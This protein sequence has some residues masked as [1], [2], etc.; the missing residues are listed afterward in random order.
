MPNEIGLKDEQR[1]K[2]NSFCLCTRQGVTRNTTE[3]EVEQIPVKVCLFATQECAIDR[4]EREREREREREK[5]QGSV[6]CR[7]Q[8]GVLQFVS[9]TNRTRRTLREKVFQNVCFVRRGT[10][11]RFWANFSISRRVVGGQKTVNSICTALVECCD[12][13]E[14]GA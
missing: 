8:F 4:E 14:G 3:P 5:G 13:Q 10:S 1:R 11:G 2:V 9:I 7:V 6:L 12:V